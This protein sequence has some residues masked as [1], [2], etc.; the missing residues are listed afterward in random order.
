MSTDRSDVRVALGQ[1]APG[2]D[3]ATNLAVIAELIADAAAHG[4]ELIVLPE[5]ALYFAAPFGPETARHAI[6]GDGPEIAQ[7]G[8]LA[9]AHGLWVVFGALEAHGERSFNTLFA[10]DPEGS[11]RARYRKLHLYD[12]F[13][14]TESEW[15]APGEIAAPETFR[16]GALRFGLQTCY[17]IRFPEVSRTLVDA[18]ADVLLVPAQWV[19]GP[20]K[21]THWSTLLAAR[22]IENTAF[23]VAADHSAPSGA[24][25]SRVLDPAGELLAGIPTGTGTAVTTLRAADR[26]RV[27]RSNPAL[28]LRRFHVQPGAPR[29]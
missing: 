24:G 8:A 25:L 1:F 10:L 19:P 20:L 29:L 18:G 15:I 28:N 12:A 6:D 3:P 2:A 11:V 27:R 9:R 21:E 4:A 22:A 17:D 14:V 23:V 13:G 7:I 16:I 5:Y 26:D